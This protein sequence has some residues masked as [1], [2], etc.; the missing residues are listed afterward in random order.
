VEVLSSVPCTKQTNKQKNRAWEME[1]EM[2]MIQVPKR[3]FKEGLLLLN[4]KK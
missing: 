2:M 1:R 3:K 4:I